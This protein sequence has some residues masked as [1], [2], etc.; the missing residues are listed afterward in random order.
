M[1]I[2]LGIGLL[3][4]IV[5]SA[6]VFLP[7]SS[8]FSGGVIQTGLSDSQLIVS[9]AQ[10]L[11][12]RYKVLLSWTVSAC[13][14]CAG[15]IR[16]AAASSGLAYSAFNLRRTLGTVMSLVAEFWFTFWNDVLIDPFGRTINYLRISL[17]DRCACA[18]ST[19]CLLEE[20]NGCPTRVAE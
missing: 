9:F 13:P 20:P 14:C 15:R 4:G 19:A 7:R 10:R 2:G 8:F 17:T 11:T 16:A 18:V 1:A 12:G 6:A 5:V 3:S